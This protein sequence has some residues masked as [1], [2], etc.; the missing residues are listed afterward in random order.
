MSELLMQG[1]WKM[2]AVDYAATILTP[3]NSHGRAMAK[4]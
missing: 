4:I 2:Y 3:T 1:Q